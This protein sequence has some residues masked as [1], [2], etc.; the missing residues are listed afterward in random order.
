MLHCV[1]A[2]VG[3]ITVAKVTI[4][5]EDAYLG[6]SDQS[7]YSNI[8]L[9]DDLGITPMWFW[10]PSSLTW[11]LV[12]VQFPGGR[13]QSPSS[14]TGY[15]LVVAARREIINQKDFMVDQA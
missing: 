7:Q 15:E 4:I 1:L 9:E 2:A 12:K 14:Y 13:C 6:R 5:G 8:V 3:L 11:T 10:L